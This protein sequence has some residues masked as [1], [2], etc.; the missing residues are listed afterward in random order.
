[1][2]TVASVSQSLVTDAKISLFTIDTTSFGGPIYHFVQDRDSAGPVVFNGVTY[3]PVDCKFD[4]LEISGVGALPTP[5][6]SLGN[7]NGLFQAVI[8]TYGDL[9]G[10]PVYR[11]RTYARFLDGHPEADPNAFYGPDI[12][13]VE[14]KVSEN[15]FSIDWELSSSIDQ[16]GKMI[17]GRQVIR[18]TCLWRYRSWNATTASFSYAKA[19]C[20]YAGAQSY[21]INDLPVASA[22]DVP[23]RKLS[24]CK[25]RF[26]ANAPLP[27]GGF[28]GAA[29]LRM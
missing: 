22:L 7:A 3:E 15:P 9:L 19:Q 17:P 21:D 6:I 1:M 12:F 28:P 23:S 10:C 4:G 18:D 13:R 16:Q 20:P 27:F 25:A 26:G 14:R 24:C 2:S 29:R 11:I 8:N 5:T